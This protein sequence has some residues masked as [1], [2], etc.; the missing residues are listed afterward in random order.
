MENTSFELGR[1]DATSKSR[2]TNKIIKS[3]PTLSSLAGS[4]RLLSESRGVDLPC[5]YQP[6]VGSI[7]N[8][9][10]DLLGELLPCPWVDLVCTR[11]AACSCCWCLLNLILLLHKPCSLPPNQ[12]CLRNV[13]CR[14]VVDTGGITPVHGCTS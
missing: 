1:A 2:W 9:N 3:I 5:F 6:S 7:I 12:H 4:H 13:S 14:R 8:W 10:S 11:G